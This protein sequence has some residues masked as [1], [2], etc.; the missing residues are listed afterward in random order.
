M[1]CETSEEC[2]GRDVQWPDE[3]AALLLFNSDQDYEMVKSLAPGTSTRAPVS[4]DGGNSK[5]YV[6]NP[7]LNRDEENSSRATA[8]PSASSVRPPVSVDLLGLS[9]AGPAHQESLISSLS[10][11]RPPAPEKS[12]IDLLA[13]AAPAPRPPA[14]EKSKIDLLAAVAPTPA[15]PA[16]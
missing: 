16:A 13:A 1:N 2:S 12:H 5:F 11:P 15:P 8:A 4:P 9:E 6:N 7:D 3:S 14:P 10:G